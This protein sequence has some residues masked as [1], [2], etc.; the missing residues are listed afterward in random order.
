MMEYPPHI[1]FPK[2]LK[3]NVL[4]S[5]LERELTSEEKNMIENYL[6]ESGF[7]HKL[8]NL[9]NVC[10]IKNLCVPILTNL[11][12]NCLFESL[13]YFGIG[14]NVT[15]LRKIVSLLLYMYKDYKY[16]IP[17]STDTLRELFDVTNEVEY[18]KSGDN[19]YAYTYETMCQDVSN[20]YTWNKLPTELILMIISYVFKLE[21]IIL[22][23][24]SEYENKINTVNNTENKFNVR[25]IYLGHIQEAHYFPLMENQTYDNNKLLY[26]DNFGIQLR[27]WACEMEKWKISEYDPINNI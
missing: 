11:N 20:P 21:F 9:H 16:F 5:Y 14:S 25:T 22:N 23:N 13:V 4:E 8:K 17:N 19:F 10:R 1:Q 24:V 27:E 7:N 18:V 12:G 3:Y 2:T 15:Q 6:I 26:Y